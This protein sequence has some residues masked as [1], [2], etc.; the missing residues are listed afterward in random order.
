MLIIK[1]ISKIIPYLHERK[2]L[3]HDSCAVRIVF[4]IYI[5]SQVAIAIYLNPK[6]YYD[7]D[8][9]LY[10]YRI[11]YPVLTYNPKVLQ[12]VAKIGAES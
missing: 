2:I 11:T 6:N 5:M 9:T 7:W 10:L 12:V 4:N 8:L 1:K 3:H